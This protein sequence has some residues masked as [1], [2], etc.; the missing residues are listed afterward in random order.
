MSPILWVPLGVLQLD[1]GVSQDSSMAGLLLALQPPHVFGWITEHIVFRWC[2]SL[3]AR[4]FVHAVHCG[5]LRRCAIIRDRPA[6]G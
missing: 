4:P 1:G 5:G 2:V 6:W 3:F